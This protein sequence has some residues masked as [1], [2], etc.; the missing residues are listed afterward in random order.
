MESYFWLYFRLLIPPGGMRGG[1][2]SLL[3]NPL[4]RGDYGKSSGYL[5]A[6]ATPTPTFTAFPA[7]YSLDDDPEF[8]YYYNDALF[9]YY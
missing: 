7:P 5:P 2:G 6:L 1:R 9:A 3:R 8:A 4:G